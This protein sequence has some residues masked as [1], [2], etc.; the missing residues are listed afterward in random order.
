MKS[1]IL[2]DW[3]GSCDLCF[4]RRLTN[5][6]QCDWKKL[7]K[8]QSL[9]CIKTCNLSA[10]QENYS[11]SSIILKWSFHI[12]LRGINKYEYKKTFILYVLLIPC[13]GKTRLLF[14][15]CLFDIFPPVYIRRLAFSGRTSSVFQL[16]GRCI[17]TWAIAFTTYASKF[18]RSL[19][20]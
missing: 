6:W 20:F 9:L 17:F 11:C 13:V 8:Y 16:P 5:G 15:V 12:G 14:S 3:T 10:E 18:A 19:I 1:A 7:G 2:A 4:F